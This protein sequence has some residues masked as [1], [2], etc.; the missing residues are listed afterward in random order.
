MTEIVFIGMVVFLIADFVAD[1]VLDRLNRK[2][3]SP[4]LPAS[5]TG[6]Y[7]V[8][9]YNRFQQYER[10]KG[11]FQTVHS[12]FSF[13]VLLFFLCAG[14]FG[15]YNRIVVG[16]TSSVAGQTL[17]FMGGLYM[18]EF[19]LSLPF[20]WY[21]TFRIEEKYGFNKMNLCLWVRDKAIGVFLSGVLGGVILWVIV[22]FYEW[23][24]VRFW[25]YAWGI[26]TVFAVCMSL[27]YSRLI[28]P[29]FNKQRPLEAGTLRDKIETFA[30]RTG[31]RLKNIYVIDGSRRSTKANAYFTGFGSQKRIVLYDTLLQE[32]TEEEVVAVLAHEMGHY[33]KHHVIQLM[34]ASL[35]QTGF[36]LWLFSWFVNQPVLSQALGGD[37]VYFQLGLVAFVIL[38]GPIE[39]ISGILMNKWSRKNEYEADACAAIQGMGEYLIEA[40]KKIS[41][42]SLSNLTPHPWYEFVNYSHPSLLKRIEAIRRLEK[43]INLE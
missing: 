32:L 11:C 5:L 22:F 43:K 12:V 16:W 2:A 4:Y 14:G 21:A 1:V 23:S 42:R 39:S 35:V 17:F 31:F 15:W 37:R 13:V 9:E 27:F 18:A 3:M 25:V 41:V 20:G 6:I 10:E 19:L 38:Y 40:L 26:L 7:Q 8:D 28:V 30:V 24:G 36:M 33:E 29:L 34:L